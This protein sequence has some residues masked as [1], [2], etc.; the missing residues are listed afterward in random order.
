MS[1]GCA[2]TRWA[3]WITCRCRSCPKCCAPRCGSSP[4]CYR[5]TRELEQL[6]LEAGTP[7][8][9]AHRGARSL[10]R[11]AHCKASRAAAWRWPPARWA[12]GIGTLGT[13]EWAWDEGQC[14]I[15]GVDAA[16]LPGH[17]GQHP[18]ASS[19]PTTGSRS[20]ARRRGMAEERA[21]PRR[22]NS[23]CCGRTARCA[24][25]PAPRRRA[26]T[27]TASGAHQRRH[28]RHH[29]PQGGRGAAGAAGARGRSSRPQRA[30]H[31][32]VDHPADPR[33]KRRRL[34]R[35]RSKAA[36]RRWRAR[37]RC[38]RIRAGT[39]PISPRWSPRNWRPTAPATRSRS[40]G[41]DISL[42]PATAQ[43][44]ALALHELA[45][46]AAKHG[47]LS[48]PS[49]KSQPRLAIAARHTDAALDRERRS[50]DRAAVGA[51][52]RLESHPRQH[53]A[54]ARRQGDVRLGSEGLRCA[55]L[56]SA[57]R[58]D[59][60]RARWH[61]RATAPSGNGAVIGLKIATSRACFWSRTR[62]WSP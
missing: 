17:R 49:G 30:R 55:L 1:T 10:E 12:R 23:A 4:N 18:R 45:T 50:A 21:H 31:H 58:A 41:P 61:R 29:R 19:I 38:C 40:S 57:Q 46:N 56:D 32:P 5:K 33:Q 35:G 51:Q 13:D 2:A 28:H 52:L 54:A 34:R 59:E 62:R 16:K 7:R 60:I 39:A 22:S 9:R 6:N 44:L 25:A 24:G 3:R 15:F 20:Q 42:Q 11:A 26:S 43:G 48:S 37:I 53:R 14:R 8:R 36:S 27:R 47:A